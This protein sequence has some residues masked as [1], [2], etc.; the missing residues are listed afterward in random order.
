VKEEITY[1]LMKIPNN[2]NWN[3]KTGSEREKQENNAQYLPP[4]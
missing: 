4:L 1:A 2:R 3:Q